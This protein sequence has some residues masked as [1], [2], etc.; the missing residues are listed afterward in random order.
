M[1]T[2]VFRQA[3]YPIYFWDIQRK[4]NMEGNVSSYALNAYLFDPRVSQALYNATNTSTYDYDGQL[5]DDYFGQYPDGGGHAL[6]IL[7]IWGQ[8]IWYK[9][10]F[11]EEQARFTAADYSCR[12]EPW[13]D[14]EMRQVIADYDNAT[15]YNDAVIGRIF[16]HY[17]DTDAVVVMLSDHGEE[18]YDYRDQLARDHQ[19]WQ[20]SE[21]VVNENEIPLVVWCSP[22]YRQRHPQV[23]E[24]LQHASQQRLM[25]DDVCQLL[26]PLAGISTRYA[27]DSRNPLSSQFKPG[28]RIIYDRVDYDELMQGKK[29]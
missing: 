6:V 20:E 24:R 19:A 15:L 21:A 8:H 4:F 9:R 10:R 25:N 23:V 5:I 18:V 28:K 22:L 7:H 26:F 3:G 16:D 29:P 12:R 11:P 27:I 17:A 1:F 14:D 2:A 13:L